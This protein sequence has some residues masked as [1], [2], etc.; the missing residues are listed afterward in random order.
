MVFLFLRVEG[1]SAKR[2]HDEGED[3][4]EVGHDTGEGERGEDSPPRYTIIFNVTIREATETYGAH[5]G[6]GK[7]SQARRRWL[8]ERWPA[9]SLAGARRVAGICSA[10]PSK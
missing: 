3:D 2:A 6:A 5:S 9:G 10:T 7:S 8:R 4:V 1:V